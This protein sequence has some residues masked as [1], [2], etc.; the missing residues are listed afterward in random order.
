MRLS[1]Q[2]RFE[3]NEKQRT[4]EVPIKCGAFL[5]AKDCTSVV[6][7]LILVIDRRNHSSC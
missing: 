2:N 4:Q 6:S 1:L 3:F 7:K 5:C